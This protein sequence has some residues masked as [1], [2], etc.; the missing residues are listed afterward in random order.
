MKNILA[1]LSAIFLL[2]IIS[3]VHAQGPGG[4]SFGFGIIL[5]DPLGG[6]VKFW[7]NRDNAIDAYIGGDYFGSPRIGADYLWHFWPFN[8]SVVNMYAGPGLALGFGY[9][10]DWGWYRVGRDS[11]IYR[12]GGGMG[13]GIRAIVGLDIVP[14]RAPIEI[15]LELG[16]LIGITPGFGAAFDAALGIRFYP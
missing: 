15:F 10:G 14:K 6:T 5:G 2:G 16:P 1:S 7:L 3:P 4:N 9:G 12:S 8:S 11:W 13:V